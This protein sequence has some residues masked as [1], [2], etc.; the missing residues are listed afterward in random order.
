MHHIDELPEWMEQMDHGEGL[1]R[2]GCFVD[3]TPLR[4]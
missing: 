2:I 1:G 4:W 3:G